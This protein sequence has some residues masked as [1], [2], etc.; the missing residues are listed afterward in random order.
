MSINEN[1]SLVNDEASKYEDGLSLKDVFGIIY[2]NLIVILVIIALSVGV[3][4]GIALN[5]KPTYTA[6][7]DVIVTCSVTTGST[8]EY[9]NY[10]L[11]IKVIPDIANIVVVNENIIS[12]ANQIYASASGNGKI[13]IANV[14]IGSS[15]E[16][17]IVTFAYTDVSKTVA[18]NK[19]NAFYK[20]CNEI[21]CARDG[22]GGSTFFPWEVEFQSMTEGATSIQT[23]SAKVKTVVIAGVIGVVLAALFVVIRTLLDDT[24]TSKEELERVTGVKLFAY[25]DEITTDE[26]KRK[27]AKKSYGEGSDK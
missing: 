10:T 3:G 24:V 21:V 1:Q 27:K 11:S 15:E 20:A 5:Q 4:L 18:E 17:V 16:S 12:R 2:K 13:E 25:I 19:L 9:N 6:K 26:I 7:K 14:D 23:N 8:S 22:H